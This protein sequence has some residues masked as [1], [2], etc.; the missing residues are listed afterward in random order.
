MEQRKSHDVPG[1]EHRRNYDVP[2]WFII[3]LR[4]SSFKHH[5]HFHDVQV[6]DIVQGAYGLGAT[7]VGL[8]AHGRHVKLA[9]GPERA[10][11]EDVCC[12]PT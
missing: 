2:A 1:V 8:V 3:V 12:I 9:K 6:F 5:A 10:D 4:C 11:N 7:A